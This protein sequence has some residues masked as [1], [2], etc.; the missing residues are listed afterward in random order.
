M[1]EVGEGQ[2]AVVA[3]LA[4]LGDLGYAPYFWD[5]HALQPGQRDDSLNAMFLVADDA[6]LGWAA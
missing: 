2:P 4:A 5:G 3:W 6:V 1:R